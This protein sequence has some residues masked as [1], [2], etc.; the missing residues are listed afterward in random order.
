MKKI[1]AIIL[2]V[3]LVLG[4]SL[5]AVAELG[6]FIESPSNNKAPELVSAKNED[7]NC[8][9]NVIITAYA[10]REKLSKETQEKLEKAYQMIIGTDD[11]SEL[12]AKVSEMAK[13]RGVKVSDL[14]VSDMFDISSV[15]CDTHEDHGHF[16]IALKSDT[17]KNFVCLLHYYNGEWHV[18]DDATVT[19]N[20]THLEFTE[21]EFSPFAIVVNTGAEYGSNPQTG[22][23][24]N[25]VWYVVVMAIS[26]VALLI[27]LMKQKNRASAN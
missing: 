26:A 7:A 22:D 23:N 4:L 27:V 14:A 10:D 16:D 24:S 1:V 5:T 11:L 15:G 19:Q 12:N 2:T 8:L 21:D 18:V 6:S 3:V 25:I 20:G 9:A 17:L 13:K